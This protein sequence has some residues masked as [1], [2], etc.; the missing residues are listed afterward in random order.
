M[1]IKTNLDEIQSYNVDAA[2]FKG[3]CSAV[4]FPE[5]NDDIVDIVQEANKNKTEITV[6][7]NRTGL[8]GSGV[9]I[10]GI[11]ISTEKLNRI[12]EI[13]KEKKYAIVQPGVLLSELQAKGL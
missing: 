9:P 13:N 1:I 4:Y 3:N 11:V 7:G 2:N 8:T 5:T 12:I 10:S 6:A